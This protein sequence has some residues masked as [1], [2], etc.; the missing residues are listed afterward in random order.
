MKLSRSRPREGEHEARARPEVDERVSV[1]SD[2]SALDFIT[3][4]S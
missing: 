4:I 2:K 3:Q 1:R